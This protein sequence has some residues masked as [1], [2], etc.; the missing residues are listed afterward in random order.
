MTTDADILLVEDDVDLCEALQEII[1]LTGHH[2]QVAFDGQSC[3]SA[4][5]DGS[6]DLI[7]LD[8]NLPDINGLALLKE[9]RQTFHKPIFMV[10]ARVD[11]DSRVRAF[12]L[13]AN[14]YIVKPFFAR[15]LELRIRNALSP[16]HSKPLATFAGWAL[17]PGNFTLMSH[18]GVEKP[19]TRAEFNLLDHLLRAGGAVVL[20]D[21]LL[22]ALEASSGVKSLESITT[23]IYRL[24]KKMQ[25]TKESNP[26]CTHSGVGY[27]LQLDDI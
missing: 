12:E 10:S 8:I 16:G 9:L 26:I 17:N 23:L 22:A 18:V 25:C 13:G 3:K 2:V 14:D 1:E 20:K 6:F 5:Q 7:I 4:Y 19:L 15:E 27:R 21:D 24:R 11:E